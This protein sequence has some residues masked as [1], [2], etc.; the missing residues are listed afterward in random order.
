MAYV[1]KENLKEYHNGIKNLIHE[2]LTGVY[3]GIIKEGKYYPIFNFQ[4][5][6]KIQEYD[7]S[8]S[9]S[10]IITV[11][12]NENIKELI[13]YDDFSIRCISDGT[14]PYFTKGAAHG[15]SVAQFSGYM[16]GKNGIYVYIISYND[17]PCSYAILLPK[18]TN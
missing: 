6:F 7:P 13:N 8:S 16:E 4:N 12:I 18:S 9:H 5:F 11:P 15:F 1:S 10:T 17:I 14:A 2:S 3:P